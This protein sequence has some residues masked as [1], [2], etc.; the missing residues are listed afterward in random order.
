MTTDFQELNSSKATFLAFSVPFVV[1]GCWFSVV[2]VSYMINELPSELVRPIDIAYAIV[3][4][5]LDLGTA[6]GLSSLVVFSLLRKALQIKVVNHLAKKLE[7]V[8]RPPT[9]YS[10][11]NDRISEVAAEPLLADQWISKGQNPDS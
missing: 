11:G 8:F 9:H 1:V 6:A 10:K 2:A 3:L 7:S 4:A 5:F